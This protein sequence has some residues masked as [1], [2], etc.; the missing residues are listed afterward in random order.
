MGRVVGCT[1]KLELRP[2]LS[3]PTAVAPTTTACSRGKATTTTRKGST[4]TRSSTTRSST[5]TTA[6]R[7]KVNRGP[8]RSAPRWVSPRC[9]RSWLQR[10]SSAPHDDHAPSHDDDQAVGFDVNHD[11]TENHHDDDSKGL[12]GADGQHHLVQRRQQG[13]GHDPDDHSGPEAEPGRLVP[14]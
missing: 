9:R 12:Q 14:R 6:P 3:R 11:G 10:R 7:A 8:A 4:T 1:A 5:T 2:V 13:I